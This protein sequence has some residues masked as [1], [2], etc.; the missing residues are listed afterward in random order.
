MEVVYIRRA[1]DKLDSKPASLD[2]GKWRVFMAPTNLL[3]TF[4]FLG[5]SQVNK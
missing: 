4:N 2:Q 1:V 5:G 3:G